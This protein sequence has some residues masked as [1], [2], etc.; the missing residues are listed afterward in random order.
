M[1]Q[2]IVGEAELFRPEQKRDVLFAPVERDFGIRRIFAA[3]FLRRVVSEDGRAIMKPFE[4][5][6]LSI[7]PRGSKTIF[8]TALVI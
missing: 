8:R 1:A 4:T 6:G 7:G 2:V 5:T 3:A